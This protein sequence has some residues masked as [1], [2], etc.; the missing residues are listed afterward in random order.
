MSDPIASIAGAIGLAKTLLDGVVG[1]KNAELKLA[2]TDLM[3]KLVDAKMQ[4][5]E[6]RAEL[7]TAKAALA[8]ESEMV[9]DSA[10]RAYFVLKPGGSEVGPFCPTCWGER[11]KKIHMLPAVLFDKPYSKCPIC[12]TST[13]EPMSGPD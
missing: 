8:E 6:L 9:M 11:R 4:V 12:K 13:W 1:Y 3:E 5:M 7:A 10:R 2:A